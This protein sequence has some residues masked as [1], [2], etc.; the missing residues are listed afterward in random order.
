M[1]LPDRIQADLTAAMKA[2]DRDT[3]ATLRLVV[4]A[5]RTLRVAEGHSGEVT[6]A[7][8]VDLLT[9]EAKRRTEAAEAYAAAGR[10]D[11]AEK[12]RHELAIIR[13][14]LPEQL[15][16][17]ELARIVDEAV[18]E[19]G[20][21]APSDLGRV[22]SAVMPRVRGRADG[23]QVNALVRDRLTGGPGA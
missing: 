20:A 9:R 14:Y 18:A 21:T 13:R 5:I 19:T 7:E 15:G 12:E 11:L 10:D 6:D 23:K 1:A 22:M 3:V 17:D 8:A 4:S 2:R 16:E